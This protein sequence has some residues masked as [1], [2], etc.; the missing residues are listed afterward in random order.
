MITLRPTSENEASAQVKGYYEQLK[1]ALNLPFV[2]IYF[3]FIG[4][5]PLY[6]S[7]IIHQVEPL[8][9]DDNFTLLT[10]Q[11]CK[12]THSILAQFFPKEKE[13]NNFILKL[14][15]SPSYYHFQKDITHIFQ[16]NAKLV[17]IFIAIREAVK[18]WAVAA[19]KVTAKS[20]YGKPE[21][22][23]EGNTREAFIYEDYSK[24]ESILSEKVND[25]IVKKQSEIKTSEKQGLTVEVLPIY[26]KRMKQEYE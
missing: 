11:L 2:P 14:K 20:E 12:T 7:Y 6:C 1:K 23:V 10:K 17:F 13:L 3:R 4:S 9:N 8:M 16:N 26:L 21:V 15:D 5:F 22:S 25:A 18:G 19:K 24:G